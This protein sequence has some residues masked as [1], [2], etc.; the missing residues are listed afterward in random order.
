MEKKYVIQYDDFSNLWLLDGK[1]YR[2]VGEHFY[3]IAVVN[4]VTT[5]ANSESHH[6]SILRAH[7]IDI[8]LIDEDGDKVGW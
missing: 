5:I 3:D 7:D 4:G 1:A 2:Y 8:E 6:L